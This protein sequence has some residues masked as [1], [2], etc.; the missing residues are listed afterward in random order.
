MPQVTEQEL[1]VAQV[2]S[3][4]GRNINFVSV[5]NSSNSLTSPV[6][7]ALAKAN[8]G[9]GG[10]RFRGEVGERRGLGLQ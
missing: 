5:Q 7:Q 10:E 8:G 6:K 2:Q 1:H 4:S 3:L 9:V